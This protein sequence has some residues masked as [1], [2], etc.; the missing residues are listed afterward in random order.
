[1]IIITGTSQ[2]IGKALAEL[3]LSKNESVIGIG[4]NQSIQHS[5]Y[6]HLKCD[7]SNPEEVEKLQIPLTDDPITFV[8]NAGVLGGI[9]RFSEL[10]NSSHI[11]IM[12]VNFNAG[13]T[14]FHKL[15]QQGNQKPFTC[16]FISS[17][18]G[19]RPIASWAGYCA[20]KAAVDLFL[21][22]VQEEENEKEHSN[23]QVYAF[24]PGVVNTGMQEKIRQSTLNQFSA[25][26][27]FIN[28]H[29]NDELKDAS[30]VAE[31]IFALI[32]QRPTSKV[33]WA[34]SDFD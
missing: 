31:K 27:R 16:V 33:L 28:F 3:Y 29:K 18:A 26:E 25:V 9:G 1:M 20:S 23:V 30:L 4:R 34:I 8:H 15:I 17:G 5:N 11:E 13:V 7:L 14:L 24:S 6:V 2:G 32:D 10:K 12:Q 21:Q 22:T 19:K